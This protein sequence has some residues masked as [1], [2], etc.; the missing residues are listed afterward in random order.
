MVK[1]YSDQASEDERRVPPR[2][3]DDAGMGT[4]FLIILLVVIG[5]T[6][7][8]MRGLWSVI[9]IVVIVLVSVILAVLEMW[10]TIFNA[11]GN[12]HIYIGMAGYLFFATVLLIMWLITM[13]VYDHQ[14]YITFSAGQM[15][16]CEEIGGGEK[17]YDTSGMTIEK[18]RDDMF[19]HLILGLGSGDL[20]V[21]TS[22][23][24][25]HTITMPNVLFISRK[26]KQIEDMQ[27]EKQVV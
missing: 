8:P 21:R 7:V 25:I 1:K 20:T 13:F 26:L 17:A 24:Q 27:R 2:V 10:G 6:N 11:V 16:V 23:A 9:I 12:L 5:I 14:L 15:K 4:L 22:G 18:H 3:T 19:R